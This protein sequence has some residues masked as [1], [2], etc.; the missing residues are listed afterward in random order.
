M[1]RKVMVSGYKAIPYDK[2]VILELGEKLT[3]L[4]GP[5][6]AGK[7]AVLEALYYVLNGKSFPVEYSYKKL[8]RYVI[9]SVVFQQ[10]DE[11]KTLLYLYT[12][13]SG[14]TYT[15]EEV[16]E[17]RGDV[18]EKIS[19][20]TKKISYANTDEVMNSIYQI[21]SDVVHTGIELIDIQRPLY[22]EG[23]LIK[24]EKVLSLLFK[25]YGLISEGIKRVDEWVK[26]L[27]YT[28][29]RTLI[30]ERGD[31]VYEFY[32]GRSGEWI[33]IDECAGGLRSTVGLIYSLSCPIE[34]MLID[35]VEVGLHPSLQIRLLEELLKWH[36]QVIVSSHSETVFYYLL[37]RKKELG[38][39][40]KINLM[41]RD[42]EAVYAEE[43]GR[44][45][46]IKLSK[47]AEKAL[48][49]FGAYG[50]FGESG[51]YS[52]KALLEG[53]ENEKDSSNR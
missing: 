25:Q 31:F 19:S 15:L 28:R 36:G 13:T 8:G 23:D 47:K 30:N 38:D 26:L 51:F 10:K 12:V 34:M 17:I 37:Y 29:F 39:K 11:L 21:S 16:V 6:A 45:I 41:Y 32:D 5:N 24:R 33:R 20:I 9:L 52:L 44:E 18:L 46:P 35:D 22:F 14:S 3:L 42:E 49:E 43:I 27:G 1:I 7:S 4:V 50:L 40:I 53:N 2:P 48:K